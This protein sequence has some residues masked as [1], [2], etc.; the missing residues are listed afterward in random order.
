[1]FSRLSL[2]YRIALVIFLLEACMLASVLGVI[3]TQSRQTANDFDAASQKASIDLLSNLSV[4]ALLT[5]EYSDYQLYI[6][7]V[8]KQP[9]LQRIVLADQGGRIVAG[10]RVTDV[11]HNMSEMVDGSETGWKIQPIDTAAGKL[12]T[13]AVKFSDDALTQAYQ[14]TRNLALMIAIAGMIVI[15]LVGLATGFA[16]TRQL[17]RV[18]EAARSFADGNLMVRSNV[19]GG[20]EVALL[21]RSFDRMADA[22]GEQQRQL[23]KQN[24]YIELLLD[25]TSEAIY[26]VDSRGICTFVNL[27]C[28]HML[29]YEHQEDLVGKILHELI[30]HTYPDGR[31][32]PKEQCRVRISTLQGQA[33]HCEDEVHW[34][35]DGSSFPV[36]YWAHPMYRDGE[37]IGAV[38]TFVDITERVHAEDQL[39]QFKTT[40]DLTQDCVFMFDPDTLRFFYV[41]QGAML[42][43]GYSAAELMRMGPLDIKP[44]YDEARLRALVAPMLAGEASSISFETR[45]RHKD[46]HDIE[47]EIF[48]QYIAPAGEPPRFVAIVRDITER[49]HAKEALQRLNEE[50]EARVQQR[51]EQLLEAKVEA[52]R[53]N[54]AKSDFL[55]RMS[56]ELRT[57][58]NAILGFGQL[59]A[60][61]T[62]DA[63][64]SDNVHEI[65]LAG[66][67]LLDLINEVLDLARIESGK[68]TVSKEPL[69]LMPMIGDCLNLIRPQAEARGIRIMDIQQDCG[70]YVRA[71]RTR[72]KQVLLNLLSNA[73]KYNRER[74]S[75]GVACMPHGDAL[76]IRISDTGAGISAEQQTRLFRAFERLDADNTGVEGTGIGLVLSKRLMELMDGGI[77]VESTPG[78]GSTFWISLPISNAHAKDAYSARPALQETPS[79]TA[80]QRPWEVLCIEDNPANLRLIERIL[81]RHRNIRLFTAGAP[82][83]GLELAQTHL[84]DLILLDINLPDMDGYAVLQCLRQGETTRD[85]PVVA[86]SA[87]ALPQDLARGKAAGFAE[88]LTKP[89]DIDKFVHTVYSVLNN[90]RGINKD[91]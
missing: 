4:T 66:Q 38:V 39:R 62:K 86:I 53:A 17:E 29:G 3:L 36:E 20:D 37:L 8:R 77:G 64:E 32:Y 6:Q 35:A 68:F 34:R 79:D 50:L 55:S 44:D 91:A 2:R 69:S 76:Q 33:V 90:P 19:A 73:V 51:T 57:P 15:A 13:L 18:T 22:V 85:I 80:S 70:E 46:G 56:H 27:A 41:N 63:E 23:K 9:S 67:H 84:P 81:A 26:G 72:L 49:K 88:Y 75:I 59:L 58:L 28:L 21:S 31:A 1:M 60:L 78:S 5:S 40:L 48:L 45:H 16:L 14:N 12:G 61:K 82:G 65:L 24:E 89:L 43:V 42:Q 83:P 54:L 71:D 7:D 11:G 30:H 52:E 10:S 25:S 87:N 74:G 47:V